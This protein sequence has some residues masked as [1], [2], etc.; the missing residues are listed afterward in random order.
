MQ[1]RFSSFSMVL[2]SGALSGWAAAPRAVPEKSLPKAPF[3]LYP[4]CPCYHLVGEGDG[5][6]RI[7][8]RVGISAAQRPGLRLNVELIDSNGNRLQSTA[9]DASAGE[10]IGVSLRVPVATPGKF[11]ITAHL[12]DRTGKEVAKA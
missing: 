4:A 3:T 1:M 7:D 12:I 8:A 9:A 10:T 6:T 5:V 11:G 2:L